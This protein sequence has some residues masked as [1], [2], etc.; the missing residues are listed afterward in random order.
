[1]KCV[2]SHIFCR[3]TLGTIWK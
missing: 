2:V 3:G 1:M